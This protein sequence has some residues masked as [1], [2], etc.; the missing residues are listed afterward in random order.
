VYFD[1]SRTL[2]V[3]AKESEFLGVHISKRMGMPKQPKR[4]RDNNE[5]AKRIVDI[6]TGQVEDREPTARGTRQRP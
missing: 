4:P 2:A 6:T 3:A 5:L 1:T